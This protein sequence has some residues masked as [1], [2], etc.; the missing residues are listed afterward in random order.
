MI[1]KGDPAQ[2]PTDEVGVTTYSTV[3]ADTLPGLVSVWL[4]GDPE[5]FTAP[6]MLPVVAPT[7]QIKL[8]AALAV[9]VIL[10]DVP[11]QVLA[12][13]ALVTAG[14]GFTVTTIEYA[15]P[16][17]EPDEEVGVIRYWTVPAL[18]LLGL[19]KV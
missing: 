6:V 8:L 11:L 19:V 10:G 4:I 5:P 13:A 2:E 1:V 14:I 9:K 16:A 15:A 7:V 12:V 17:H 18:A 3:P